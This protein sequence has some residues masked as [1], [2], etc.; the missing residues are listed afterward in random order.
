MSART[1]LVHEFAELAGVTVRTLHYYDQAGLLKPARRADSLHRVYYEHDL[2]RLQQILTLKALGFSLEEIRALLDSPSY[3]V[4]MS[5]RM[6]KEAIDRR[7]AQLQEASRTLDEVIALVGTAEIS[8]PHVV[9][10]IRAISVD[11]NR[12]W[13]RRYFNEEQQAQLAARQTPQEE[14][15]AGERAWAD[16]IA[17]FQ[18]R[19]SLP[20][21]HPDVQ[22]LAARMMGLLQNFTQGDPALRASLAAMYRDF[23]QIPIEFRRYDADLQ[24]FMCA[25]LAIYEERNQAT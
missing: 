12:Q 8:W 14:I 25:A 1:Y 21:D 5:L 11:E 17:D 18:A 19:R 20:P 6:Q 7:I 13:L 22:E 10:L 23:D 4:Q 16:L 2:L 9:T 24:P 3:D 15:R